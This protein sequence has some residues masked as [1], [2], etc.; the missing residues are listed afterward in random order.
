MTEERS[1]RCFYIGLASIVLGGLFVNFLVD[2]Y[3][4]ILLVVI[5]FVT[6]TIQIRTETKHIFFIGLALLLGTIVFMVLFGSY[7]A[8][9][10]E[11]PIV[12][13]FRYIW[14][15]LFLGQTLLF[16]GWSYGD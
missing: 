2:I 3:A 16:I 15:F 4:T 13:E 9:L 10:P 12:A 11:V 5:G 6:I 7:L 14:F 8:I 1:I